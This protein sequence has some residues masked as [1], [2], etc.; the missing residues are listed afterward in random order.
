MGVLS[1]NDRNM[2]VAYSYFMHQLSLRI[3]GEDWEPYVTRNM[4][5][6]HQYLSSRGIFRHM[7]DFGVPFA[8]RQLA[9][10]LHGTETH[11]FAPTGF[12]QTEGAAVLGATLGTERM[13]R[14]EASYKSEA[15]ALLRLL[16]N[17]LCKLAIDS[18]ERFYRQYSKFCAALQITAIIGRVGLSELQK[19]LNELHFSE[20]EI[21]EL[22]SV[23]TYPSEHTPLFLSQKELYEI[24]KIRSAELSDGELHA[25]IANWL[26]RH[27]HIPVNFCEE[28]WAHE[29]AAHQLAAIE[30]G[31]ESAILERFEATHAQKCR[32]AD[33]A[34]REI[35]DSRISKL[36]ST[37]SK[38]TI[39][40]EF[41]KNV[42]SRVSLEYRPIFEAV[43][44]KSGGI[45]WRDCWY[46]TA[47]E[48]GKV[49]GGETLPLMTFK[50]EREVVVFYIAE[51]GE[52]V[53]LKKRDT[54]RVYD[55]VQQFRG[56]GSEKV[57]RDIREIRGFPAS[58]GTVKGAVKIVLGSKD[59][60][61]VGRGDI[62][63]AIMTSVDFIPVMERAAAFVTNEGGI[64]SHASIVA[65]EM[66]KPCIIGTKI[67]TKVLKDG[68]RVEV[69]AKRGVVKILK[70][71]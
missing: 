12:E 14:L 32:D 4:S 18:W 28:P 60:H 49:I 37:I 27:R 40:N 44:Q 34:L 53:F 30:A 45:N 55:F 22:I 71:I 46:L 7:R 15:A 70:R 17:C 21:P 3:A 66:Q 13:S 48:M 6:W 26:A 54:K 31:R 47:E 42:F 35:N 25:R 20:N 43:A 59:F 65:R 41:R 16:E 69:D 9:F 64:T 51:Q 23:I 38:G 61:K 62:L 58:K 57:K 2:L 36:A 68:D 39:L 5:F 33:V 11:I 10:I 8:S 29:D 50:K 63:V 1:T 67:A 56:K 52:T 19:R 24:A